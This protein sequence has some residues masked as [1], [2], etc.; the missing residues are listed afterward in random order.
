MT[1]IGTHA[2]FMEPIVNVILPENGKQAYILDKKRNKIF[3]CKYKNVNT[4]A[5]RHRT[6]NMLLN[7]VSVITNMILLY[8]SRNLSLILSNLV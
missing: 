7:V 4:D 6:K 2:N 1:S 3:S 8:A 5:K